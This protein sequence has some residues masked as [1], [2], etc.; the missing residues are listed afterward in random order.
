MFTITFDPFV[1]NCSWTFDIVD[2]LAAITFLHIDKTCLSVS[3]NDL[4]TY[5]S[6]AQETLFFLRQ[7]P[8]CSYFSSTL[9]SQGGNVTHLPWNALTPSHPLSGSTSCSSQFS[10]RLM[11]HLSGQ[12]RLLCFGGTT[13]HGTSFSSASLAY[14][15]AE[16]QD[17][18]FTFPFSL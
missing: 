1:V 14:I 18:P 9:V 16:S 6:C 15:K 5:I 11:L 2:A 7:T 8:P 4:E 10:S 12:L 3:L 17:R 13:R